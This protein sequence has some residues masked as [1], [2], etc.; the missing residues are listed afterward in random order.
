[1]T[2]EE[3]QIIYNNDIETPFRVLT[4]DHAADSIFLR[5][6][7]FLIEDA[8]RVA[9]NKDMQHL[10]ARLK[11]TM[12]TESGVGIAAP[13]IGISRRVFL[14]MR[15][16]KP[17][18]PVEVAINPRIVNHPDETICFEGDGCLSIPDQNGNTKRYAWI[19]VEYY[20]EK[21]E[22]IK[23]RL[24]GASRESDFTGIIFQHEYDHLDGILFTDRLSE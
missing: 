15:F 2:N 11:L 9:Q 21:G 13:Q 16:D 7:S 12:A 6:K 19:D 10:I 3:K 24:E 4:V 20:N 8:V 22:L 14:F 18:L 17:D 23:E 5:K 1:M